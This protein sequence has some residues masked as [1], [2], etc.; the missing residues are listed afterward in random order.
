MKDLVVKIVQAIV[1]QPEAVSVNEI[2]SNQ[3]AVLEVSVAKTD[4]GKVIGKHG[5]TAQAIRTI[6]GAA[7]GKRRKRYMVE[8]ID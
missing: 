6:I 3:T 7:A 4:I 2:E 8:I 5:R 1:D